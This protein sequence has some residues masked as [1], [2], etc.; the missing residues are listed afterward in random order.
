MPACSKGVLISFNMTNSALI[1]TR[2]REHAGESVAEVQGQLI[3]VR[4]Y[5][6]FALHW[7]FSVC[8]ML[9]ARACVCMRAYVRACVY[10]GLCLM[11]GRVV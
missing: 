10:V 2:L 7:Y 9:G 5:V 4:R 3:A 8:L 6:V 11:L 1:L